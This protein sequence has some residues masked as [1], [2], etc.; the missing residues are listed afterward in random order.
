MTHQVR[1]EGK[2][3]VQLRGLRSAA[4]DALVERVTDL[5]DAPWDANLEERRGDP[6]YRQTTFGQG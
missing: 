5:A 4:F 3:L 1:F 2:A 6:A